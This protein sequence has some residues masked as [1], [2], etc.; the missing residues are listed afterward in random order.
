MDLT[1]SRNA[2]EELKEWIRQKKVW[3]EK[4]IKTSEIY[5]YGVEHFSNRAVRNTQDMAQRGEG[6][7]R[8]PREEAIMLGF[9]GNEGIWGLI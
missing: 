5:K 8:I 3:G 6:L 9:T 4:Y 7:K 1:K 2:K